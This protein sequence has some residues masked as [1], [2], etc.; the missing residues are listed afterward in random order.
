MATCYIC[1]GWKEDGLSICPACKRNQDLIDEQESIAS[2][3]QRQAE[4]HEAEMRS[5]A[6]EQT[7][8]QERIANESH[9]NEIKRKLLEITVEGVSDPKTA[10][11]KA[12]VIMRSSDFVGNVGWFWPSIARND[13]LKNTYLSDLFCEVDEVTDAADFFDPMDGD[14]YLDALD[15]IDSNQTLIPNGSI[16][17]NKLAEYEEIQ[18]KRE[19]EKEKQE[20]KD[21][22]IAEEKQS[23]AKLKEIKKKATRGAL[24]LVASGLFIVS[25]IPVAWS[26]ISKWIQAWN[27]GGNPKDWSVMLS[28]AGSSPLSSGVAVW[29]ALILY[30]LGLLLGVKAVWKGVDERNEDNKTMHQLFAFVGAVILTVYFWNQFTDSR[31]HVA[32]VAACLIIPFVPLVRIALA[33]LGGSISL[34]YVMVIPAWIVGWIAGTLTGWFT[35]SHPVQ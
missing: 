35:K 20:E 11:K 31:Y 16:V 9:L 24:G 23:S 3:Q 7:A 4:E 33:S 17:A 14:V 8:E 25:A 10:A 18:T 27:H 6:E 32:M 13:F 28:V 30:L 19:I 1:G 12:L 26:I 29:T 2:N 34:A 15:W 21:R 22:K 5:I